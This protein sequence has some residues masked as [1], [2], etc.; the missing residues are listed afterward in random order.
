VLA[1]FLG[2]VTAWPFFVVWQRTPAALYAMCLRWTHAWLRTCRF[3]CGF[4]TEVHGTPPPPGAFIAPNHQS[5]T[6][7]FALGAAVPS[8]FVAKT[9]VARWPLIGYLFRRSHQIG[10]RRATSR[11]LR[12]TVEEITER[13][14]L[15]LS[16]AVF[17]EGTTTGGDGPLL[18]FRSPLLQAAIDSGAP[19]VPCAIRW[20]A[21]DPRVVVAEDIAY[22]GGHVF[23]PHLFHFLGL[24]GLTCAIHFGD[25][26]P[27]GDLDRKELADRIRDAVQAL[28]DAADGRA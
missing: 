7:V 23:G 18:P 1:C 16:V 20:R 21:R 2:F 17:L 5:Y 10:V 24:T 8:F 19:I 3:C 6:D 4:T 22:W 28:V 14:D 11:S 12:G 15:G 26:I 25:P 13:L 27:P 9:E